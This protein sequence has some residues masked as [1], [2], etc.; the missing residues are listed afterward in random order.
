M[1]DIIWQPGITLEQIEKQVILKA[2]AF[3]RQNKTQTANA[4]DIAIRTL[5]HKLEEYGKRKESSH[6]RKTLEEAQREVDGGRAREG[7]RVEPASQNT[8]QSAVSLR[9]QDQ[10]QEVPP[11]QV[12]AYSANRRQDKRDERRK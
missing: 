7:L 5:D 6:S 2:F 10:V 4:L 12:A 11:R 8:S 9:E 3:F 1:S